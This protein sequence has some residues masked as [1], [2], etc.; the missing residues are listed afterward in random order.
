MNSTLLVNWP[1]LGG[2]YIPTAVCDRIG[3]KDEKVYFLEF[4]KGNQVLRP[5]QKA[6]MDL[7]PQMYMIIRHE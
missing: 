6:I 4:K 3:V 5:G 2:P 7:V 1:R